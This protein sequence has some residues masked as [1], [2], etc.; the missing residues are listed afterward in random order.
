MSVVSKAASVARSLAL[1]AVGVAIGGFLFHPRAGRTATAAE[2]TLPVTVFGHTRVEEGFRKGGVLFSD[3]KRNYQIHTSRR[4]EAGKPELH[5]LDT[6]L[7]YIQQGTGTF[8][9]GGSLVEPKATGPNE[10]TARTIEGGEA[11]RLTKGDVIIIPKGVPH[12]FKEVQGPFTYYT[13]KV[14]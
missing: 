4:V 1:V 11:H 8:V 9:T 2:P 6:D 7:F 14:R 10:M 5:E 13:I 12:W 3:P